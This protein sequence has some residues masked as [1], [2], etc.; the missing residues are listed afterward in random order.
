MSDVGTFLRVHDLDGFWAVR[1]SHL[2]DV[3][4]A[5]ALHL[6]TGIDKLLELQTIE[7]DP[8]LI[9]ASTIHVVS[10]DSPTGRDREM[11]FRAARQRESQE[12]ARRHGFKERPAS[13]GDE[14]KQ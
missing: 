8:L 10:V 13:D 12:L 9:R 2:E 14:W 5:I 11:A 4:R 7:G 6:E 1:D 3:K